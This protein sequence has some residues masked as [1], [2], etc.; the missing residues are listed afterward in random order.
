MSIIQKIKLLICIATVFCM[1]SCTPSVPS[2]DVDY[3][4]YY[5]SE[6]DMY[7]DAEYVILVVKT[8]AE[9]NHFERA[10]PGDRYIGY[11]LSDVK[12]EKIIKNDPDKPID[13]GENIM[14]FEYSFEYTQDGEQKAGN[15][16]YYSKM[17]PGNEYLLY[18]KYTEG[19]EDF[20]KIE[21]EKLLEQIS[22]EFPAYRKVKLQE[23]FMQIFEQHLGVVESV[24]KDT[25]LVRYWE[26]LIPAELSGRV[27]EKPVPGSDVQFIWN[28]RGRSTITKIFRNLLEA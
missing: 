20:E 15:V 2:A 18:L 27:S 25:Y 10:E 13:I 21:D 16:N 12:I 24:E 22:E 8:S 28:H 23:G 17:N 9:E 11:T 6:E 4:F 19:L 1:G 7:Q 26:L 5:V 14:V 3:K